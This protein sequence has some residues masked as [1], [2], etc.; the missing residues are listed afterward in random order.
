VDLALSP[1]GAL[2]YVKDDRGLV[3]IDARSWALRQ[4]LLLPEGGGSMHGIAVTRRDPRRVYATTAQNHLWEAMTGEEGKAICFTERPD[5]TPYTCLP[6]RVLLDEMN[7]SMA[8][9]SGQELH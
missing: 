5:L 4:E 3:V 7:P 2:L 6:K 9:L 1:D 8:H